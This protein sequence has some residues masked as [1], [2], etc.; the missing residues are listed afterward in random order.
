MN[1]LYWV[2]FM[3]KVQ[4]NLKIPEFYVEAWVLKQ[5]ND[6][7]NHHSWVWDWNRAQ[8]LHPESEPESEICL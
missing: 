1:V 6:F 2:Q 7:D 5:S 3:S 8:N 4:T